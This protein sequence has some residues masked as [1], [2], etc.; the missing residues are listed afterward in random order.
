MSKIFNPLHEQPY[1]LKA[2]SSAP[3]KK[4]I[5][6]INAV[7]AKRGVFNPL[8]A[9]S[10]DARFKVEAA[11]QNTV[12]GECA[13]CKTPMSRASLADGSPMYYCESCR[14]SSPMAN[15]DPE[16]VDSI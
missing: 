5:R 14:V 11:L 12:V 15:G 16:G 2:N 10:A 13:K 4:P 9:I 7:K 1:L 8:T 6:I 3:V